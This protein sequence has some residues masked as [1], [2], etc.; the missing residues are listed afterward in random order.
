MRC[1][2]DDTGACSEVVGP[3]GVGLCARLGRV[4]RQLGRDGMRCECRKG[5]GRKNNRII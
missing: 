4:C 1:R 2:F 5:G 3:R